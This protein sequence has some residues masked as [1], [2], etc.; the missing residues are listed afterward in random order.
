MTQSTILKKYY[1]EPDF[2]LVNH[3][4]PNGNN[5]DCWFENDTDVAHRCLSLEDFNQLTK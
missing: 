2:K 4:P 1:L 3:N 5:V